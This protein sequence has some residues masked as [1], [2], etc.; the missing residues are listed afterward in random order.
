MKAYI[1]Y[2]YSNGRS[3]GILN[4]G[5][6]NPNNIKKHLVENLG[7]TETAT[8]IFE[9]TSDKGAKLKAVVDNICMQD[10]YMY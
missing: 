3:K 6:F 5:F 2:L 7:Y 10:P 1:A 8:G 4:E 9:K